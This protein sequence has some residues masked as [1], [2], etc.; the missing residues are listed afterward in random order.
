MPVNA[1]QA[2]RIKIV[3]PGEGDIGGLA[4]GVGVQFKI[5]AADTGGALSIVEHTFAPRSMVPPHIHT[6]EDE[7]SIVVEGTVGFRSND[8]EVVL[9]PG[10]Y[11]VKPREQVHAMWNAGDAPARIIEL[12]VPAGFEGFFRGLT[13]MTATGAVD[14][15]A[16]AK[17]AEQYGRRPPM[18]HWLPDVVARY[19]LIP[20]PSMP[21]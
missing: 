18:P 1:S 8:D 15:R 16:V 20:P 14:P 9:T 21:S 6:Q 12:I 5:E 10:A 17:L 13:A 19:G 4:P 7:I 11:I 3:Q 2:S